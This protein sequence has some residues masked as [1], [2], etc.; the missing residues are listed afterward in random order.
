MNKLSSVIRC[1]LCAGFVF[2]AA[3]TATGCSKADYEYAS[4]RA[5]FIFDNSIHQDKT[6]QTA[7]N[8]MSPG[9]FCRIWEGS[10]EG[11]VF[12]YFANNQGL[13]SKQ[14]AYAEEIRRTR[15]IGV[16][17]KSGVIVG[18]GN[19]TSPAELYVYDSQCP[20]C[21]NS[22]NMANYRLTLTS[23]GHAVCPNCKRK[24]DLNSRGITTDGKKL[25]RY[26]ATCSGPLGTLVVNN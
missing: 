13:T 4:E 7:T 23:D 26:R 3:W 18:Y 20:N 6:L 10:E 8:N 16:Y 12:F 24:Y 1:L 2:L 15:V 11:S 5:Y 14:K 22:T 21:Y 9:V 17:N 19:L 25:M